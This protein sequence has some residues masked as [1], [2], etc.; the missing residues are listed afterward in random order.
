MGS[1]GLLFLFLG[2]YL[3]NGTAFVVTALGAN[4]VRRV[5]DAVVGPERAVGVDRRGQ[6]TH[7]VVRPALTR[8][9]VGMTAFRIR[10]CFP[11]TV[12][13]PPP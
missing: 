7:L 9:G 12:Y 3:E 5:R 13:S 2:L 10:H 4:L 1:S 6:H 8:P 11:L